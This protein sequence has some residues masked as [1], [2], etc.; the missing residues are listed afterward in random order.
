MSFA[1][2]GKVFKSG[3]CI[4]NQVQ[5]SHRNELWNGSPNYKRK[6]GRKKNVAQ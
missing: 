4:I 2:F 1:L 3:I 5:H 6:S